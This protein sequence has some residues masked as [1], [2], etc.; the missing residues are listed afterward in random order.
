[1]ANKLI[2]R[3]DCFQGAIPGHINPLED[4]NHY[5]CGA[6]RMAERSVPAEQK[7]ENIN[8][9]VKVVLMEACEQGE[10]IVRA[11]EAFLN[12]KQLSFYG[13]LMNCK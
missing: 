8:K 3:M 12:T 10:L 6:K 11:Q 4:G 2:V 7:A 13:L 1:M 9:E 5:I